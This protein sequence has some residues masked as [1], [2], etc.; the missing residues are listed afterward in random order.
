[1]VRLCFRNGLRG[2]SHSHGGTRANF[3]A[4]M[5][6]MRPGE[7]GALRLHRH[8]R[9]STLCLTASL[10]V[11]MSSIPLDEVS[12]QP[13]P[14]G[15]ALGELLGQV[16]DSVAARTETTRGWPPDTIELVVSANWMNEGTSLGQDV[17]RTL[18]GSRYVTG[19]CRPEPR[20]CDVGDE[21]MSLTFSRPRMLEPGHLVVYTSLHGDDGLR[22]DP[23]NGFLV[24]WDTHLEFSGEWNVVRT[25]FRLISSPEKE[26]AGTGGLPMVDSGGE[27]CV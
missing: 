20:A 1:M 2:E 23:S 26:A 5:K 8:R 24:A 22:G 16:I 18:G 25:E 12:G 4:W 3:G 21:V 9:L 17:L 15:T 14:T 27:G 6:A 10:A 13:M 19:I 7:S 11:T